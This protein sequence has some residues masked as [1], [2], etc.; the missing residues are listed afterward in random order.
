MPAPLS[1]HWETTKSIIFQLVMI[2]I[3]WWKI[4][5]R[6]HKSCILYKLLR[7]SLRVFLMYFA[8]NTWVNVTKTLGGQKCIRCVHDLV[9]LSWIQMALLAPS[10][11]YLYA[12]AQVAH[13]LVHP[14]I[15]N[16]FLSVTV[17]SL[18][19]KSTC[20]KYNSS[21]WTVCPNRLIQVEKP[22]LVQG[23]ISDS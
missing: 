15:V 7:N 13:V 20:P 18:H 4:D 8:F 3:F 11:T 23:S 5:L 2:S 14:N 10:T 6:G 17:R 9:S 16:P 12:N 21:E 1:K 22:L 19:D